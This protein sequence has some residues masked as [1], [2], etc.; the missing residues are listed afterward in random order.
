MELSKLFGL[1][2]HPLLV[3]IPIV[4]L[5]LVGVGAIAMAVSAK[6]RDR[7]GWI[8]VALAGVSLVGVQLAMGSGEQLQDSVRR[9]QALSEHIDFAEQLRPLAFVLFLAVLALMLVH[10]RR[11]S[12]PTS[13]RATPGWLLPA[14]SVACVVLALVTNVQLVR[15]GHNGARATW[16]DVKIRSDR[17]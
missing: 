13:D 8:V 16:Q 9:T 14:A 3:H 17:D 6:A 5:P 15:V 11:Q 2:A 10:R 1:P 4:L 7:I 12:S